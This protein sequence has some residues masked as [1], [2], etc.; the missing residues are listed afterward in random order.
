[1]AALAH[2]GMGHVVGFLQG[3]AH[4]F[5]GIDHM[6]AMVAVGLMAGRLGGRAIWL[7]PAS[8]M[9]VMALGA[10]LG[11][12]GAAIPFVEIGIAASILAF[13]LLLASGRDMTVPA[14]MALVGFFALFHGHA[15]GTEAA[16]DISGFSY[17]AGLLVATAVLHAL[18]VVLALAMTR[19]HA[20]TA[21]PLLRWSGGLMAIAGVGVFAGLG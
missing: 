17:E 9:S 6:L 2:T 15:H 4:S 14:T 1:M 20:V 10:L 8:F 13:G 11:I 3:L 21:K 18:G 7:V 12:A 16:R 5:T 19:Y